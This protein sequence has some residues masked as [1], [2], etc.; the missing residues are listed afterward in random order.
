MDGIAKLC[1][2][3]SSFPFIDSPLSSRSFFFHKILFPSLMKFK[4]KRQTK[5]TSLTFAQYLCHLTFNV[6]SYI[7]G[8]LFDAVNL[9]YIL[10][11]GDLEAG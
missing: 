3:I 6:Q 5:I 7:I 4:K 10:G 9:S 1:Q 11:K 2:Q 8:F